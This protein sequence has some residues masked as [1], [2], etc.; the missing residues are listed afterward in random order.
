MN[1]KLPE[2]E[3]LKLNSRF[4]RGRI[5][6]GL[7]DMATGSISDD[8]NK[9]LK[10]HGSYMQ[11]HRDLRDERRHQKLEPLYSFMVRLR[12]PGGV[13]SPQ[14]WL[15]L[16]AIADDC[17][18]GT[19]RLTTRQT[20]QFH[21]I[22]KKDLKSFMQQINKLLLDSKG[23]CGDV[24]RNVVSSINPHQSAVHAEVYQIA[25][26]ISDKLCWQS[27]AY[28]E[29]WLGED[30][31]FQSGEP[32]EPFY[33]DVY[34]PRKFKIAIAV[35]PRNDCDVLAN[36]I[37][38]IAIIDKGKLQGF[39]IAVG[40]GFG[41]SYGEPATYPRLA[42]VAGFV[43]VDQAVS[44]CETIA[45]IQR[46]FGDRSNRAHA[47]FKYT[48]DDNGI[49]WFK[50]KFAEYHGQPLQA[51]RE[52]ELTENGDK[53]GWTEGD[54]GQSHLTLYI[55]GGRVA[56][57]EQEQTRTGLREIAKILQG[58]FRITCNQNL[59]IANISPEQRGEIASLVEKYQLD[60]GSQGS[61]LR[62]NA[63]ACVALPTCGLAMAEAERYLP[64][65]I[66][67]LE[68]IVVE[69]GLPDQLINIRMTGCPN[70]CA[71][72]YLGEIGLTGK[73]L[74]KYNLY[75]GA[76]F[77][78]QRLNRL[79]LENV[80]EK[81]ILDTLKPMIEQFAAERNKNEYFGDFLLRQGIVSEERT[82][83]MMHEPLISQK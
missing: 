38:L 56:D 21:E 5:E 3:L 37:G 13:L 8:D 55:P 52:F 27:G 40:G 20:F 59:M 11:D 50:D 61:A 73:A 42:T 62:L 63:M 65:F 48:I 66:G 46:D 41:M 1:D 36:D 75:L 53:F 30:K 64:E 16:D 10:F 78:G 14:Q 68:K 26:D 12:L 70:G 67:K 22:L 19:L 69:A 58:E 24:N 25:R 32:E 51:A 82:P 39:N 44:A 49:D 17:S 71:R 34:L 18:N 45:A 54:N 83:Q 4:L 33:G 80:D 43:S 29:I 31:V 7:A 6:E 60:D 47:R 76:D 77:S 28:G 2:A 72:P 15:G 35:P 81:T 74:G 79:Y 57:K 9:L 23:A